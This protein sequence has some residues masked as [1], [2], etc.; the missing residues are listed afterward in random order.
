[1]ILFCSFCGKSQHDVRKLVAGPH[2]YI[3]DECIELSMAIVREQGQSFYL[4]RPD[5]YRSL[6][7]N[8]IRAAKAAGIPPDKAFEI[9]RTW[10]HLA[11]ESARENGLA[12]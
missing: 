8:S 4:C 1:M 11:E 3:C 12:K 7:E 9:G 10:L 5:E 2:V 6:A